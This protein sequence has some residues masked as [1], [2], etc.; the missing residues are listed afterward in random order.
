MTDSQEIKITN[1]VLTQVRHCLANYEGVE[2]E[3]KLCQL[4][5][6]WHTKGVAIGIESMRK[7][8]NKSKEVK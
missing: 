8:D 1:R 4:V 5:F 2:L 6:E 7:K 3:Q